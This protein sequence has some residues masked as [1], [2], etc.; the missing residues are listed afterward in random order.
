MSLLL[1]ARNPTNSEE[2]IKKSEVY[3]KL[4]F[5]EAAL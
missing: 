1:T 5:R 3:C 2:N 4:L